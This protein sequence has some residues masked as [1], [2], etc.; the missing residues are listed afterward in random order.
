MS[1]TLYKLLAIVLAITIP[2]L[3]GLLV[4]YVFERRRRRRRQRQEV[5]QAAEAL[6]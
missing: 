2:L 1:E 3:W 4:E 6:E 5:N